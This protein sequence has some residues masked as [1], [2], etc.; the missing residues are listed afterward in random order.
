VFVSVCA[1]PDLELAIGLGAGCAQTDVK[2][3]KSSWSEITP[4]QL[5]LAARSGSVGAQSDGE[6]AEGRRKLGR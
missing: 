6:L 4:L 3:A 1:Q 2:L 5:A